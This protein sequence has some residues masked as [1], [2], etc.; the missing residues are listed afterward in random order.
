MFNNINLNMY[1][2]F[3]Y[4]VK[5][6]SFT[7]AALEMNITQPNVSAMITNLEN[8][9]NV[10]L[11]DR[12]KK[13]FGITDEGKEL[14]ITLQNVKKE[15]DIF[16]NYIYNKSK[17]ENGEINIGIR[18][19]F[20]KMI[21]IDY[22]KLFISK[23]ADVKINIICKKTS[24]LLKMLDNK[25]IDFLIGICSD[26][27]IIKNDITIEPLCNLHPIFVSKNPINKILN[28]KE[29]ESIP[30]IVSSEDSISYN[31]LKGICYKENI[32]LVPTIVTSS[33]DIM[34]S[35]IRNNLGIGYIFRELCYK[36]IN[37]NRLYE[38]KVNKELP[39]YKIDLVYKNTC[40][41]SDAKKFI[42]MII[43][44]IRNNCDE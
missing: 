24:T 20:A 7:K 28:L 43:E 34:M 23:Y 2:T 29:I 9:M 13:K 22:L 3:Y 32:K 8:E 21:L 12:G 39:T 40:I 25:E 41:N 6:K 26:E 38:V 16:N 31:A 37:T 18:Q 35:C 17:K 10:K 19:A 36:Y 42:N 14:Y 15:L 5:N 11:L 27:Y 44:E 4:V 30:L 33:T 1:R